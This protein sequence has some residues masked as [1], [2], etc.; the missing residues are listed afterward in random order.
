MKGQ[1]FLTPMESIMNIP[2]EL[3][4]LERLVK[5]ARRRK[6]EEASKN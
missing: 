5:L 1:I 2:K 4:Y 3:E 6:D